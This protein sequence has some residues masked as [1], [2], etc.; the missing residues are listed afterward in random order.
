[1]L[2]PALMSPFLEDRL[3]VAYTAVWRFFLNYLTIMAG[4]A[5]LVRW[6]G[7]DAAGVSNDESAPVS[8]DQPGAES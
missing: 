8:N 4:G 1:M 2:A 3:L 5:L 6:I 7:Q